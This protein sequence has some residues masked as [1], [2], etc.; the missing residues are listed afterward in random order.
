VQRRGEIVPKLDDE[1]LIETVAGAHVG[2]EGGIAAFPSQKDEWI[3]RRDVDQREGNHQNAEHERRRLQ[4]ATNQVPSE[5]SGPGI[6]FV[7]QAVSRILPPD[8]RKPL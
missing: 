7:V 3:T 2:V 4:Q 8:V 1:R 6:H 5:R